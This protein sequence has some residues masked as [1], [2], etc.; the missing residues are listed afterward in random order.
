MKILFIGARL[1]DDVDFYLKENNIESVLTESNPNSPNLDCADFKF[2]VPRGMDAPLKIA[3]EKSVKGIIPLIGIDDPLMDVAIA[4]QKVEKDLNI[5]FIASNTFS[6]SI[7]SDK[8]KTKEFFNEFCIDT[9][10]FQVISSEPDKLI[11]IDNSNISNISSFDNIDFEYPVVLK[12]RSGQ[13]GRDIFIAEN[14]SEANDYMNYHDEVLC[15]EFIEGSE[16][17]IEVL[18]FKGEYL[19]LVPVYKGE[20]TFEGIHPLNKVRSAPAEIEGLNNEMVRNIA[21]NIAKSLKSEGTIDID[22][23]FSKKDKKLYALEVNSR[24]SG[25]RYLTAAASGIHP[26][27]KLIDMVQG[28]FDI[29][30][31]ENEIKDYFALEIP[32]MNYS[33]PKKEDP[34][35]KF[36]KNSWVVHGPKNYERITISG[37]SKEKTLEL[38][39]YLLGNKLDDF[40]LDK[41]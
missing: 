5:P 27:T 14:S 8:I 25:T 30:T 11:N 28:N 6:I 23:I 12:Q 22:F 19:P 41:S 21:Y 1:F 4:K 26:L 39:R 9:A 29:K 13:G 20:T 35:K 31:V 40:N 37:E 33:G 3:K 24:P 32:I 34:Q 2:I 7:T 38:A 36:T 18:G 10:K 16:I 17:S 15:E